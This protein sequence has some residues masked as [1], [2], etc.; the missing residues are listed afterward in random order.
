MGE[1]P[2]CRL[3]VGRARDVGRRVTG[4]PVSVLASK[5]PCVPHAEGCGQVSHQT[6]QQHPCHWDAL[7]LPPRLHNTEAKLPV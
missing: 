2:P 4:N 1:V 6:T 5:A 3:H 7:Q